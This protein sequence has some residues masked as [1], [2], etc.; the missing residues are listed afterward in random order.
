MDTITASGPNEEQIKYWN[1]E[2]GQ[3]W[4][5]AQ[6]MLDLQLEKLGFHAMDAAHLG[7]GDRVIDVGCGCGATTLEIARRVGSKGSVTGI[8]ISTPMLAQAQRSAAAAGVT[9]VHFLNTDAQTHTFTA[10]SADALFSRFGVMFFA[11]PRAA[12]ANLRGALSARGRL[13]FVCWRSFPEN[14]WVAV[15]MMAAMQLVPLQAPP[16]PDAPGPFAFAD[17]DRVRGILSDAGFAK[18]QLD[19]IDETLTVGGGSDLDRAVE[20][21]LQMGPTSRLL[22]EADPKLLPQVAAAVRSAL[23]PYHGPDG[24]QMTGAVWVVTATAS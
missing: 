10:D 22:R 7:S 21:L 19:P 8:D 20:F 3:K 11:D 5:N 15:P 9:N 14:S 24:V 17:A 2:S 6:A 12:F 1:D 23:E 13:G 4:V 18:M 16:P